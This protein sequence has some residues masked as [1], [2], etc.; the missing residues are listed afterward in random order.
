VAERGIWGGVPP[1]RTNA[2]NF[3]L[4][5]IGLFVAATLV[6]TFMGWL[7][8]DRANAGFPTSQSSATTPPSED[9]SDAPWPTPTETLPGPSQPSFTPGPTPTETTEAEL[10]RQAYAALE[11]QAA[12]DLQRTRLRGQWAAQ[13]SSKYVGVHDRLQETQSGSHTFHAVDILA[14]HQD[15]R[16]RFAGGRYEVRLLRGQDFSPGTTYNG[17]TLWYTFVLGDFTSPSGVKSFCRSAFPG[18]SG[19]YLEN[20][21]LSRTLK[22]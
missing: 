20:H 22:P 18:L 11:D 13:L 10:E 9:P 17:E 1:R 2:R 21:C 12:A 8:A 7:S 14:E 16:H 6:G 15:L 3:V 5:G 19:R 4:G